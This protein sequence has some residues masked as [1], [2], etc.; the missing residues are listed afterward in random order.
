MPEKEV[1]KKN[2]GIKKILWGVF[3]S[4]SANPFLSNN[5]NKSSDMYLYDRKWLWYHDEHINLC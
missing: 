2:T 5:N 4:V 3:F 1:E